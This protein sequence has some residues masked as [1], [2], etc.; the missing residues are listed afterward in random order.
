MG[1]TGE[2]P[3]AP[4]LPP[5]THLQISMKINGR[6]HMRA[7]RT[8]ME[9]VIGK[10]V[11]VDCVRTCGARFSDPS[12]LI[13]S[14]KIC[15]KEHATTEDAKHTNTKMHVPSYSSF[16]IHAVGHDAM[17]DPPIHA[18][19]ARSGLATMCILWYRCL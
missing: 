12:L 10:R 2:A 3:P 14:I 11:K 18:P 7:R 9:N 16:D 6:S 8:W 1:M 15:G 13:N 5:S 19:K 4:G 17:I